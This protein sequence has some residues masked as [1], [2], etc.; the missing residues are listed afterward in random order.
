M[1]KKTQNKIKL[2]SFIKIALL[3]KLGVVGNVSQRFSGV[4]F[5]SKMG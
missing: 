4:C 3:Q 5:S 2:R 1:D